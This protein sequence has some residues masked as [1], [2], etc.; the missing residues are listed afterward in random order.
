MQGTPPPIFWLHTGKRKEGGQQ[1]WYHQPGDA[2]GRTRGEG[3]LQPLPMGRGES[4]PG[5]VPN[6][7]T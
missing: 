2:E 1:R 5:D 6:A 3:G 4:P 7:V